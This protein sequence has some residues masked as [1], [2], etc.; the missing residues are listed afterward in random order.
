MPA[1]GPFTASFAWPA[2]AKLNLFLHVTGRRADGY[3]ELQTLFQ[4]IDLHD[5]LYFVPRGDGEFTRSGAPQGLAEQDDLV[6]RAARAIRRASG[7]NLGADIRV[8]KRIPLGAGLGGGSSNAATTLIALNRLWN[9][10]L[11]NDEIA[12]IGLSLGADVPV[13]VRGL[14]A[15]GEGVGERLRPVVIDEPHYLV[16]TP[17]VAVSTAEIFRAPELTRDH[18]PIEFADFIAGHGRNDCEAATCA[19]YPAVREALAWLRER[20]PRAR[21]SGTGASLFAAFAQRSD[22]EALAAQ[23]PSAWPHFIAQGRNRSPL[24]DAIARS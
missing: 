14:A 19:R 22:A 12:R 11:P 5:T 15:W 13:F 10:G 8:E 3:H 17:P 9:L 6:L 23:L 4:F 1:A 18:Q 21:M 24:L 7:A 16:V 20:T 2:P